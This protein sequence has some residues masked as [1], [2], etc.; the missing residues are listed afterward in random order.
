MGIVLYEWVHLALKTEHRF[1]FLALGLIY[2]PLSFWCCYLIRD[3]Y[4][5]KVGLLFIVMVWASDIG[6]Y[7]FGK[8]IGGP[9]LALSIS[10]NKTW[11]GLAGAVICPGI[12]GAL[13]LV[14]LDYAWGGAIPKKDLLYG[15]FV[16]FLASVFV[17]VVGQAG[18]LLASVLKRQAH[19]KDASGLIPGHGGLLDRID[20]MM[21]S[22]PAFLFLFSKLGHV[23]GS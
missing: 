15:I 10:P 9:K 22:A 1:L 20:A 19:V 16:L 21:L 7:A 12:I 5:A 18:D 8:T 13:F 14:G 23:F 3:L 2:I 4:P 11:A 6:A 17:G